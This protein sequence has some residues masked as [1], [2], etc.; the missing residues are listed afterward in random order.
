MYHST[1]RLI[2]ALE[3]PERLCRRLKGLRLIRDA[4]GQPCYSVGNNAVVFRIEL[5]GRMRRLR[6][7]RIRPAIDLE[8]IYGEKLLREEL[9]VHNDDRQGEWIDVVLD[10]WVEG[11]TLDIVMDRA[12]QNRDTCLLYELSRRVDA[13]AAGLLADAWAQ[14]DLKPENI[15]VTPDGSLRLIDFDARF[16]PSMQGRTSAELGTP[17]YQH[18]GRTAENFDR[19][20]DHYPAALISVQLRALALD[21]A[22]HDRHSAP[23][24]YLIHPS[25]LFDDDPCPAYDEVL[26][27]FARMG[28]AIHYRLARA[29]KQ[30]CYRLSG[31]EELF[32]G[33]APQ[34]PADTPPAFY[35]ERGLCGFRT[36]DRIVIPPVYDEALDFREGVAA[37][38][39]AAL[40][41]YIDTAGN[42]VF[43]CPPDCDAAK[44][45]RN[46]FARYR[47]R[48]IWQ[49]HSIK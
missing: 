16:L 11:D 31:V 48:G 28:D 7:Y 46:G 47:C 29:L 38:R 5:H 40:W 34:P 19:W 37:V 49:E 24:E 20:L 27:L 36:G 2:S 22:L 14:G 35:M 43:H 10:D 4:D 23:G 25:R 1:L 9:F 41:H 33:T 42:P 6:C 21:P 17:T 45:L 15:V 26:D 12:L 13:L 8:A 32:D 44:S 30:P 3:Q 18:P 39:L